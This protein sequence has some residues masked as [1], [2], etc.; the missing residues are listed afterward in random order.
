ML[1]WC[2]TQCT[3]AACEYMLVTAIITA[4]STSCMYLEHRIMETVWSDFMAPQ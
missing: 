3:E 2:F 1:I 4:T